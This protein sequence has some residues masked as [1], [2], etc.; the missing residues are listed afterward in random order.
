MKDMAAVYVA[1]ETEALGVGRQICELQAL[2]RIKDPRLDAHLTQLGIDP[3]FYALRWIRLWLAREFAIPDV[4][5]LWD[6]FFAADIRLPWLRYVCVSMLIRIRAD[7]LGED[8]AGCM[9]LLLHYPSCDVAELLQIADRLRT[10][11]VTIVRT[12]LR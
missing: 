3:R 1:N 2:L 9:K 8:F 5:R 4:L 11:N 6:S 7:L 10:A 12:T